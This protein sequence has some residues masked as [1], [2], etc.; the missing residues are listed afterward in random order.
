MKKAYTNNKTTDYTGNTDQ[1]YYSSTKKTASEKISGVTFATDANGNFTKINVPNQGEMTLNTEKVRDDVGYESAMRNYTI[2]KENYDRSI[3]DIN[4][5][6]E[7]IQQQDKTL[8]LRLKQLDT[9]QSALQTE[10]EAV[11]KVIDK[12]VVS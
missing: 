5:Q 2:T 10:L 7:I 4:A 9:E 8:E 1:Y 12:N 3:A 11:T 6:T